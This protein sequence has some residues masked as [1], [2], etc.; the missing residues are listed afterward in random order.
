MGA[1]CIEGHIHTEYTY[2]Y[3]YVDKILIIISAMPFNS[4]R[5]CDGKN[6][7]GNSISMKWMS[8]SMVRD[9]QIISTNQMKQSAYG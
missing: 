5:K 2:I 4:L 7:N 6:G 3:I 1:L 8:D 9:I